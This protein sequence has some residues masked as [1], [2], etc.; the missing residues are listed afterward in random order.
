[1]STVPEPRRFSGRGGGRNR[2][3]IDLSRREAIVLL[4]P[5]LLPILALSVAPLAR[6]EAEDLA[7]V[8]AAVVVHEAEQAPGGAV[9]AR[10]AD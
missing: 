1:M 5:A 9:G 2:A 6:G 3:G 7:A 10:G 8:Q 4:V